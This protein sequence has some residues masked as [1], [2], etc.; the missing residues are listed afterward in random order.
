M[1]GITPSGVIS[2]ISPLY[3]GSISDREIFLQSGL[4]DKLE[5][6][7]A[8]MADKGFNIADILENKGITLNIGPK[9]KCRSA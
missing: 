7:V 5:V 2:F 1:A 9:E 4:L 8:V 3:G 6:G